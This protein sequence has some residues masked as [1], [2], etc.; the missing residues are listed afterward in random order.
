MQSLLLLLSSLQTH[1]KTIGN[2]LLL[3]DYLVYLK[4]FSFLLSSHTASFSQISLVASKPFSIAT[5]LS[6]KWPSNRLVWAMQSPLFRLLRT[7]RSTGTPSKAFSLCSSIWTI[8]CWFFVR[9]T[10]SSST[11]FTAIDPS[12]LI[13]LR[14]E[15]VVLQA[16]P[17]SL[18]PRF[19]SWCTAATPLGGPPFSL[20]DSLRF[21]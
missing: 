12:F 5:L 16:I 15:T 10:P 17:R 6:A 1:C 2:G 19:F 13:S 9:A 20:C 7:L 4:S 8:S 18:S 21:S 14:V 11:S 3:P